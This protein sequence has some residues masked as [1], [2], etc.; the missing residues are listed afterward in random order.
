MSMKYQQILIWFGLVTLALMAGCQVLGGPE[1][2]VQKAFEEYA[3]R[4]GT[5]Y[6]DVRFQVLSNDG[7][8]ATVRIVAKF[9]EKAE[10]GWVEKQAEV[11]CRNV[12]GKWQVASGMVFETVFETM[13]P[14][15]PD[16]AAVV[17]LA[18]GK[19]T[20]ERNRLA[21]LFAASET[22]MVWVLEGQA[23]GTLKA[24][25]SDTLFNIDDGF[26]AYDL[27]RAHGWTRALRKEFF[28]SGKLNEKKLY[29]YLTGK[30][31]YSQSSVSQFLNKYERFL[32]YRGIDVLKIQ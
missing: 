25:V 18:K 23:E 31:G 22:N 15:D 8:F 19:D 29:D 24:I 11:Q 6:T 3:Q 26:D 27:A 30:L 20:I 21:A 1:S 9:R 5:P 4:A 28:S 17:D 13:F 2:V 32:R 7:T 14:G 10:M 16:W 12:G